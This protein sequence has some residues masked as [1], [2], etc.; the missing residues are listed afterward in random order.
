MLNYDDIL[1][2]SPYSLSKQ[3]KEKLLTLKL[4]ELTKYHYEHCE[5]YNRMLDCVGFD[6]GD[7]CI[8]YDIPFLP[9]SLFKELDLLSIGKDNIIKTM[10]S[11]GTTG[12]AVSKIYL[13]KA[14]ASNQQK[15]LVKIVSNFIGSERMPMLIIDCPSV[16]KNKSIFS[17]RSAGILGFSIFGTD[18]TYAL[19]DDMGLNISAI[20][21]FLEK[22]KGQHILMFGFTF[23]IWQH[24]YKALKKSKIKLDLSN[25]ILIHGG[26][27]KKLVTEAVSKENFKNCLSEVCELKN[28]HN[29]YGMVEQAGS[30]YMECEHGNLHASIFSDII[31]R[32]TND[33]SVCYIGETG[34]VQVI[35]VL[36]E[37]YPGHSLL[38]DDE[39]VIL[40]EDDC[41]CGRKGKYFEIKGRLLNAEIRGCSDTYASDFR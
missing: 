40:G 9:V 25:G 27:W 20:L 1:A 16:L 10:T 13:D 2:V 37:S 21:K 31:T 14:T 7:A 24:F 17:A 36:P 32:R 33:F 34:I 38:T 22:H 4:I 29:Y 15:A 23:M 30:I 5:E 19:D 41:L 3:E 18:N 35:S 28:I 12:Q 11:S 26:G 39:G 6:P 8:Y